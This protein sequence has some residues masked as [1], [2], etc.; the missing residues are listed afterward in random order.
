M[1]ATSTAWC[2]VP[3]RRR[4]ITDRSSSV[5]TTSAIETMTTRAMRA[6]QATLR[7]PRKSRV[8]VLDRDYQ[9][10]DVLALAGLR[11]RPRDAYRSMAEEAGR[12]T[13]HGEGVARIATI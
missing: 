1:R 5:A 6:W 7:Q 12:E 2:G 4:V 10:R 13:S 11:R 3:S 8:P 9:V